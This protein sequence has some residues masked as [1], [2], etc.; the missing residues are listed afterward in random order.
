MLIRERRRSMA[1]LAVRRIEEAD[2]LDVVAK[3]VRAA[4]HDALVD[5]PA[6]DQ[7]LGGAW[8]GH[9]V[10][11]L[12]VQVPVG[13]WTMATLLD[14]TDS[15]RHAGAV[16]ALLLTGCVSALPAIITGAHDLATTSGE[17]TR[18]A[19]VHALTMDAA[20]GLFVTALAKRRRGDRRGARRLV[21]AGTAVTAAGAY[22]GGHMVYRLGVGVDER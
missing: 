17:Q 18:V 4:A 15:D 13:A 12:A 10:H 8:L 21:L 19:L 20:L 6:A 14:V 1:E 22:L 9:R 7:L 5:P 2:G 11:P 16:D 3:H